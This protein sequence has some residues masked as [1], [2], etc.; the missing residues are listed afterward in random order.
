MKLADDLR[1]ALS[2]AMDEA[3][4]RRHEY[5]TLEHVLLALLHDPSSADALKA[6]GVKLDKLERDLTLYL[7]NE[8]EK[9]PEGREQDPQQTMAFSRVF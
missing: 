2:R 7:D 6:C 1:I 3:K 5:L 4:Q 8:V 9:M